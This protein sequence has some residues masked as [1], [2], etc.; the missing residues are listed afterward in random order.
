MYDE[1][2]KYKD[3]CEQNEG[4]KSTLTDCEERLKD[5]EIEKQMREISLKENSLEVLK[6]EPK[7]KEKS[8]KFLWLG[9]F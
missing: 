2:V 7:K 6:F 9:I 1:E 5:L 8:C 3:M 4:L